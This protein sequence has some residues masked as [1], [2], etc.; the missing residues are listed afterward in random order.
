ML[1]MATD[2]RLVAWVR[3]GRAAAFEALYARHHRAI[4]SFCHHMLGS[5]EEAE[6][7]MQHTFLAAYNGLASSEK[8]MHL[9]AWLFTIARNRCYSILR[10]RREQPLAEF[11]EPATEGLATLVQ[12]RQDLRDLL[13]DMGRLP[14]E[15]RAALVLAEMDSLSHEQ[16]GAVL[17]VPTV[18]VKAL[19][20]QARES[21][22]ASR[23]A[24]EADC[25][26]IREQLANLRGGALRRTQL[27]RHLRECAGCREFRTQIDQQ[28]RQLRLLIP[29]APTIA[30]KQTLL[31]ASG[32]GA[33]AGGIA[34]SGLLTSSGLKGAT[35]VGAV[36]ASVGAAG[37]IVAVHGVPH[38]WPS[39]PA[40]RH[41]PPARVHRAAAAT[42]R[43]AAGSGSATT[44]RPSS[45]ATVAAFNALAFSSSHHLV[46][47]VGHAKGNSSRLLVTVRPAA[48]SQPH[49][50]AL[51]KSAPVQSSAAS[52]QQVLF[53]ALPKT[54]ASSGPSS[55]DSTGGFRPHVAESTA[56]S[57]SY[58]I[59]G[60]SQSWSPQQAASPAPPSHWSHTAHAGFGHG[61][62]TWL[63][64][65]DQGSPAQGAPTPGKA[66]GHG[67]PS[68][69]AGPGGQGGQAGGFGGYPGPGSGFSGGHDH[70]HGGFGPQ[71]GP[72]SRGGSPS[73]WSGSGHGGRHR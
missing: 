67:W 55:G 30:I 48:P 14:H 26:E 71:G 65:G 4:L 13:C 16:I 37:T 64:Q 5:L 1:R 31:S 20:F 73:R 27:R 50:K 66:D 49:S 23:S 69:S 38:V 18:K 21:L 15:Q 44:G 28:R 40:P 32:G 57:P 54:R 6:D 52:W 12:R 10:K 53:S 39:R 47:S 3:E 62:Q 72:G 19:V 60:T 59:S 9:R 22:L 56:K 68:P 2:V 58:G 46:A 24:R 43:S 17:E 70:G 11:A 51:A 35:L 25:A 33:G 63:G 41:A 36:L 34:G 45:A 42:A 7:A 29:V 8:P 61:G